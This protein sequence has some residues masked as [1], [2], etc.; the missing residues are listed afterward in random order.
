M[1]RAAAVELL[2]RSAVAIVPNRP[3]RSLGQDSMK[4]YDYAARGR[5][6]VSTRWFDPSSADGPPHL[7][8]AGTACEFAEAVIAAAG[9]GDQA[10]ED[11]RS[12]AAERTWRR[13]W[14]QWAEA[15]FGP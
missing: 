1:P 8:L 9:Q 15:V 14:P 12:W 4:F 10:A 6:I 2:D 11:R 3:D 5:P 13:R 7:R